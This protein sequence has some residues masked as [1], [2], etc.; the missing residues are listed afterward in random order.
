MNNKNINPILYFVLVYL[1]GIFGIHKFIDGNKKQG[2]LYLC[3]LGLCGFGWMYDFIKAGIIAVKY[4]INK[5]TYSASTNNKDFDSN[6]VMFTKLRGV[7]KDCINVMGLNRQ[8]ALQNISENTK[9]HLELSDDIFL[10]ITDD[11]GID[12]GEISY[13]RSKILNKYPLSQLSIHIKNITG[14]TDNK[15]YGCNVIITNK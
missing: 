12:L 4:L 5:D 8:K 2:V 10:A 9:I 14:G 6:G 15:Y 13:E 1:L 11:N 7:T 3:T